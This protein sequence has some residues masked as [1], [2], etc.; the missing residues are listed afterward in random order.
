MVD[1]KPENGVTEPS[2]PHQLWRQ[3]VG[4]VFWILLLT[5]FTGNL[6]AIVIG[7]VLGGLTFADAWTSGLYKDPDKKSFL[8]MSPMAWGIVMVGLHVVAYPAYLFYRYKMRMRNPTGGLFIAVVTLGGLTF[9]M[10]VVS[11]VRIFTALQAAR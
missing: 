8:N 2:N 1:S 5:F 3:L 11:L 7:L 6:L 10:S 9:Y 4:L